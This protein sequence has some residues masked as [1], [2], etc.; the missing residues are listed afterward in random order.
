[1]TGSG[2]RDRQVIL[3]MAGVVVAVLLLNVASAIVPGMDWV[4]AVTPVILV[5]L[6]AIT[7]Y[8]LYRALRPR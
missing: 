8:V 1:V 3:L 2:V 6:V 5:L 7:G 4:L